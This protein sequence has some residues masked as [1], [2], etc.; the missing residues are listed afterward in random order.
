MA[1]TAIYP[2]LKKLHSDGKVSTDGVVYAFVK[3]VAKDDSVNSG[4]STTGKAPGRGKRS[5]RP[6]QR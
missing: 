3:K 2:V 4:K 5:P 1:S 6:P